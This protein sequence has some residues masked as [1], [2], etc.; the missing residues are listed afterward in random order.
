[1]SEVR[2]VTLN[3][4]GVSCTGD[5]YSIPRNGD[6]RHWV[7]EFVF[8]YESSFSGVTNLGAVAWS[9]GMRGDACK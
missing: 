2:Q 4:G 9:L 7:R 1:M 6:E 3:F 5:A 8:A